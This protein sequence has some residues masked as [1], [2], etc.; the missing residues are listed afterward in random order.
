M[1]AYGLCLVFTA[2]IAPSRES[3][4]PNQH[5]HS[6]IRYFIPKV[7]VS[8]LAPKELTFAEPSRNLRRS[9]VQDGSVMMAGGSISSTPP[10]HLNTCCSSTAPHFTAAALFNKIQQILNRR[11][12]S[13]CSLARCTG[14]VALHWER[15]GLT[16]ASNFA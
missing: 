15:F 5:N 3:T 16:G 14:N 6:S 8:R 1:R 11:N 4:T 13:Y 12:V 2:R 10:V 9:W 7:V